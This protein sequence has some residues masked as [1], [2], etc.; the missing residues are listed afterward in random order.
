MRT[1]AGPADPLIEV[2]CDESG[3][4]GE[5]LIGGNCDVFAHAGVRLSVASAAG[6][7]QELRDR[8]RSPALEYKANHLLR[9]KHRSALIWL[10]GPSGPVY[11]RASVQLTQKD[12]FAVGRLIDLLAPG[13][14][15]GA[16]G[17]WGQR[18]AARAQATD[19][20]SSGPAVFGPGQWTAFL[21]CFNDLVRA[22][23]GPAAAA[24]ADSFLRLIEVMRDGQALEGDPR[25]AAFMD[26]I[27]PARARAEALRRVQRAQYPS[28]IPALDPLIPAIIQAV[29][30][31]SAG[32]RAVRVIHDQQ[33]TLT[34]ERIALIAQICNEPLP[35]AKLK[36]GDQPA[37]PRSANQ[38][39]GPR[40]ANQPAEVEPGDQPAGP[41]SANQPAGPRSANQPAKPQPRD[42][43]AEPG[44]REQRPRDQ[45]AEP[46]PRDQPAGRPLVGLRLA[47]SAADA[48]VQVADFLAGVARK[49]ASDELNRR[50]DAELTAL[51]RPY[52]D[53][54]S[55]WGDERSW[56][57]L[58]PA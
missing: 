46:G 21:E 19:L 30:H 24:S 41:R 12:F 25:A 11:S 5:K 17:H 39:A 52:V 1:D 49:I 22:K 45:P 33:T 8:I 34:P 32:G 48:R 55:V 29:R 6:C 38:P 35:P 47:D 9:G 20:Y 13:Q 14:A 15:D 43:P 27:W 57:R 28:V 2:A 31:W 50:G 51:L 16:D 36:P 18:P 37:G 40:S 10:L 4:E 42:Q 53:P 56:S 7:V 26:L 44:A 3:A 58:G 23:H 54:C